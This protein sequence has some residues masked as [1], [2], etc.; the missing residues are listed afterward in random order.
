MGQ[1][2]TILKL[3]PERY[4]LIITHV[5]KTGAQNCLLVT[6]NL[7]PL[8]LK[9]FIKLLIIIYSRV[10]VCLLFLIKGQPGILVV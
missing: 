7:V 5:K 10:V 9:I 8:T 4:Y 1:E 3:L 6:S 2:I